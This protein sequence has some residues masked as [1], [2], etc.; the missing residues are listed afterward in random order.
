MMR[1]FI[2][3]LFLVLLVGC[4]VQTARIPSFNRGVILELHNKERTKTGA[5]ELEIDLKLD[6]DAQT[7]AEWMAKRE[8]LKHSSLGGDYPVMGENIAC[9]QESEERVMQDWMNSSGHRRNILNTQFKCVG[10]GFSVSSQGTPYWC[11]RF[12]GS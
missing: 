11:V 10:F 2:L 7:H 5:S 12:G 8:S 4:G 1:Q 9:G 3:C 6:N